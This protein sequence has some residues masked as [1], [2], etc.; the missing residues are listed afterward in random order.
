M[1][2]LILLFTIVCA[3][4][5]M[6]GMEPQRG[7]L[8]AFEQLPEE[9]R[10]EIV[11]ALAKS[12]DLEQVIGAIKVASI[13]QGV[14]YGNLQS[15]TG[16]VRALTKKFPDKS[17]E[18]IILALE[19]PEAYKEL[20]TILET[21]KNLRDIYA[22]I[23]SQNIL[24]G[25]LKDFTALVHILVDKKNELVGNSSPDRRT[26]MIASEFGTPVAETYNELGNELMYCVEQGNSKQVARLIQD[27]ADVNFVN[28]CHTSP[29]AKVLGTNFLSIEV[30]KLLLAHGADP[31][32]ESVQSTLKGIDR[33]KGMGLHQPYYYV[34]IDAIKQLLEEAKK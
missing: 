15:A 12:N 18:E 9:L 17:R 20:V 10:Q 34:M 25:N 2:K 4:G 1:K 22:A 23:K 14:P 31:N 11:K 28:Y 29:L 33:F 32:Q 13:F 19:K 3:T 5:Q 7:S 16:L 27:G 24:Q 8:G 21:N 26:M 6:Y 30:V